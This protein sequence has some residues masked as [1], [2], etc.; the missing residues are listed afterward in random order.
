MVSAEEEEA[1]ENPLE[2]TA[3]Q[4][5]A[6]RAGIDRPTA[7][8]PASLE[9]K[10]VTTASSGATDTSEK[11][12]KS[13]KASSSS[14]RSST[15]DGAVAAASSDQ[16]SREKLEEVMMRHISQ[17]HEQLECYRKETERVSMAMHT[18]ERFIAPQAHNQSSQCQQQLQQQQTQHQ[19]PAANI[20]LNAIPTANAGHEHSYLPEY[21]PVSFACSDGN[22]SGN[23]SGSNMKNT[24]EN[25]G[26]DSSTGKRS[27]KEEDGWK[28]IARSLLT[29]LGIGSA[30]IFLGR[31]MMHVQSDAAASKAK[32]EQKDNAILRVG[33]VQ[34]GLE[35]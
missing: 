23:S 13:K 19:Q 8:V 33:R 18:F 1:S 6:P 15:S 4:T 5:I 25:E 34:V 29:T 32:L 27:K 9:Q 7:L 11:K 30:L 16:R 26:N 10:A 3:S 22:S 12:H 24:D 17:L 35:K 31:Y 20:T 21:P 2:S 28:R 14:R